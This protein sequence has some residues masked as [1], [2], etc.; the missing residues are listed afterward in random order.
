MGKMKEVAM[1]W[2]KEFQQREDTFLYWDQYSPN[3][4]SFTTDQEASYGQLDR[5][6]ALLDQKR[7][8]PKLAYRI[9]VD[10][11]GQPN[12]TEP[13]VISQTEHSRMVQERIDR[14]NS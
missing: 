8:S 13:V 3:R 9:I 6:R 2:D 10:L 5:I 11:E 14:D 4:D 1:D 12:M 7:I